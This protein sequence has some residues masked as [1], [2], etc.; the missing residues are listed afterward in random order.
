MITRRPVL[1][2]GLPK[3]RLRVG[4]NRHWKTAII[5]G[6]VLVLIYCLDQP[7]GI[8]N[9]TFH[10]DSVQS[11]EQAVQ[12]IEQLRTEETHLKPVAQTIF[13]THNQKVERVV[14][15]IHGYTN[16]PNQFRVLGEHMYR[17]GFNVLIT[18]L[19]YH[20]LPNRMTD[21]HAKLTTEQMVEY[22]NR[23]LDIAQ[24]LGERVTI[25][26][27]SAGGNM[28]A[29]AAHNRSDLDRAVVIAPMFGYPQIPVLITPAVTNLLLVLPNYFR[30]W[31]PHLGENGG[32]ENSYPRFSTRAIANILRLGYAVQ[33]H[34]RKEKIVAN[35]VVM[36]T[37]GND[38]AVHPVPI[39]NLVD[40]WRKKGSKVI[41]YEY[42][43][44]LELGHDLIDPEQPY[45]KTD[46]VYPKLIELIKD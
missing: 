19:P 18:P 34:A 2:R 13:L 24:G 3:S 32:T 4:S 15:F 27:L 31:E 26:G 17:L 30:W 21:E 10:S 8:N 25:V 29:W 28:A 16:C 6:I 36:V 40:N 5:I 33:K 41:T 20:G 1:E 11:Y 44:E 46:L 22:T 43:A 39:R 9:L 37:N 38:T 14:V 45:A 12:R 35:S 23:A 42:P 7:W